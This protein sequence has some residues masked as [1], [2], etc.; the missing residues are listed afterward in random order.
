[1]AVLPPM[2]RSA[3]R[4]PRSTSRLGGNRVVAPWVCWLATA[5]A[6]AQRWHDRFRHGHSAALRCPAL[7]VLSVA[8]WSKTKTAHPASEAAPRSSLPTRESTGSCLTTHPASSA[9][10]SRRSN[11]SLLSSPFCSV[12]LASLR[13]QER[14]SCF[15]HSPYYHVWNRKSDTPGWL[16]N[17]RHLAT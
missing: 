3:S 14:C 10:R 9:T 6:S 1:M 17:L 15:S 16:T 5:H 7:I 8:S 12:L 13:H 4:T 2:C 11:S